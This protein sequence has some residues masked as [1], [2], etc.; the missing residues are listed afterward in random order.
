MDHWRGIGHWR[1]DT[2]FSDWQ[3]R[4]EGLV[5]GQFGDDAIRSLGQVAVSML[6]KYGYQDARAKSAVKSWQQMHGKGLKA[7]GVYGPASAAALASD[8]APM[9]VPAAYVLG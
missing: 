7:D 5:M 9:T 3:S 8:M 1:T 4:K 2:Y 6:A